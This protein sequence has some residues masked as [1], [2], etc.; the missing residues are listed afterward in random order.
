M[1]KGLKDI[2]DE[3]RTKV[4]EFANESFAKGQEVSKSIDTLKQLTANNGLTVGQEIDKKLSASLGPGVWKYTG[5][6]KFKNDRGESRS[7]QDLDSKSE[8]SRIA[9]DIKNSF[10]RTREDLIQFE[11]YKRLSAEEK[12]RSE[13]FLMRRFS[14]NS[15]MVGFFFSSGGG[16][17]LEGAACTGSVGGAF[18]S[19]LVSAGARFCGRSK[20][21]SVCLLN[22][23]RS[24]RYSG[25]LTKLA[26]N[27]LGL[28]LDLRNQLQSLYLLLLYYSPLKEG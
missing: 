18:A 13:G 28:D 7:I 22:C 6:G 12:R 8:A 25:V 20:T 24:L 17:E 16:F 15:S 19:F 2:P 9:S 27:S 1:L 11:R 23:S 5:E 26:S 3:V 14:S 10:T 21:S 4:F